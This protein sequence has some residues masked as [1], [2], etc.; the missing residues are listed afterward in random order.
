MLVAGAGRRRDELPVS[1]AVLPSVLQPGHQV[2]IDDGLVRLRVDAV[3]GGTVRC[4]V[5]VGG[6]V[7]AHKG[8]NVP[9]VPLP[10]P[11]VTEKDKRRSRVRARPRRRLRRA[12][13]RALGGRRARPARAAR[14][15]RAPTRTIIAKIEKAE[16]LDDLAAIVAAADAVMV[17]RGDLG[18][19]IGPA[20]VPLVQKRII[21]AALEHGKPAITATQMLES[22]ISHA[23]PTRAE[24]SD[25]ANAILDGTSAVMLSGETAVGASRSRACRRWTGSRAPSSRASATGTSSSAAAESRT[26]T[27]GEAMS[28]AACDI[29]E[30]LDAAA[31][32]VPTY[33]GRTASAVARHRPRRPII[34]VTHR[35]SRAAADGARVGRRPGG[36]R[37]V[38][39]RAR[40]SGP[41]RS[42]R[43]GDRDRRARR[44]RRD[45]GGHGGEHARH[46]E[47]DQGRD[48]V[49]LRRAAG[50]GTSVR[51]R[52]TQR[53]NL[54]SP[55]RAAHRRT[56]P[57]VAVVRWIAVAVVRAIALAFVP[58]LRWL[59]IAVL[60]DVASRT[61]S[62][63][64][65]TRRTQRGRRRRAEVAAL[66]RA[67]RARGPDR[68]RAHEHV[69]R[70]RGAQ[71]R[72]RPAGRAAL[73]RQ[74][75]R[76][77]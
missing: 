55:S 69:R 45:H 30:V 10:I 64:A 22:M 34:A 41:A 59:G 51:E 62:R 49:G 75:R 35:A 60:A 57:S 31:I 44:P 36:D 73:H 63:C 7:D 18:V 77:G 43:R 13:V 6:V 54:G 70:A 68:G 52:W 76:A 14:T 27:V 46:D 4:T 39:R 67:R 2:L 15:R 17:A 71:A 58:P 66:E 72:S 32:L 53:E 33:S 1:P 65:P 12:L 23:E 25:V 3:D 11:S 21:L 42:R 47:P 48:R 8:V 40:S 61:S 37:G 29:A 20:E 9:G 16:A 19:E 5:L 28:N 74:G 38:P 56:L 26:P 50:A 24:A